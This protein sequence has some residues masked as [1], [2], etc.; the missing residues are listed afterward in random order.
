MQ[1]QALFWSKDMHLVGGCL[2]RREA[3]WCKYSLLTTPRLFSLSYT[4]TDVAL[5]IVEYTLLL[6]LNVASRELR[7]GECGGVRDS[8]PLPRH[9]DLPAGSS[10][11]GKATTSAVALP[12]PTR[13]CDI[14]AYAIPG[15]SRTPLF[16]N[17]LARIG[18]PLEPP[19]AF[20]GL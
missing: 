14:H 13:P 1:L 17:L 20:T 10:M 9:D 5:T 3:D 7:R 8:A 12:V 19:G 18:P 4:N 6:I 2:E 11:L 16:P 15:R